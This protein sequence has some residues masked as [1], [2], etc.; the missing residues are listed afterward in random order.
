MHPKHIH[1]TLAATAEAVA[2]SLASGVLL[3][4]DWKRD[5]GETFET[6]R[7]MANKTAFEANPGLR[8]VKVPPGVSVAAV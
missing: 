3:L 2:R 5:L 1:D 8:S 6:V 7:Q 4:P